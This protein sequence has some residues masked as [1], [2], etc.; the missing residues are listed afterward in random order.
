M[1]KRGHSPFSG[2]PALYLGMLNIYAPCFPQA[3]A[4]PI[5]GASTY[6]APFR[7]R[8]FR[9]PPAMSWETRPNGLRHYTRTW[10]V[11]GKVVRIYIGGG[12]PGNAA[13][14]TDF[15]R[16]K[17]IE[18]ERQ[19]RALRANEI[20]RFETDLLLLDAITHLI[21]RDALEA[22][23]FHQH[24]RGQWRKRRETGH[25]VSPDA[26]DNRGEPAAL[27]QP[28]GQIAIPPVAESPGLL[29]NVRRPG[30]HRPRRLDPQVRGR[31]L[32]RARNRNEYRR[33]FVGWPTRTG[34]LAAAGRPRPPAASFGVAASRRGP[35]AAAA[36]RSSHRQRPVMP[37]VDTRSLVRRQRPRSNGYNRPT[38]R[39]PPD[40]SHAQA[41]AAAA[42]RDAFGNRRR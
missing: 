5:T 42:G 2:N 3:R 18:C 15:C 32:D 19:R 29:P 1:Q 7:L 38:I 24:A 40:S 4:Q 9:D 6:V 17:L 35:L 22:A 20:R 36:R 23:G 26:S 34:P 33:A 13:A 11:K 28:C 12:A 21:A 8:R 39:A 10:R 14:I 31:R 30:R 25:T 37:R 41:P 16:R 27:V